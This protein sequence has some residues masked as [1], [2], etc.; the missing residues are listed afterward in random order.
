MQ[1]PDSTITDLLLSY[2]DVPFCNDA[3]APRLP[4]K[5]EVGELCRELLRIIF[6]G[7]LSG[8]LINEDESRRRCAEAANSL[9]CQISRSLTVSGSPGSS[10]AALTKEFFDGLPGIRKVIATDLESAF[11]GDPAAR[12]IGEILLS[13]PC[14]DAVTIQRLAYSLYEAGVQL[15]PR[16]MTEWAHE[17]TGIDIHPGASIGTH[18]SSIMEPA[19]SS[20]SHAGSAIT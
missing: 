1:L 6:P 8:R 5:S 4:S 9:E 15:L 2:V 3:A 20:G 12:S 19:W 13:Y 10:A 16:M 17:R 14:V 7:R 18:F 11:E